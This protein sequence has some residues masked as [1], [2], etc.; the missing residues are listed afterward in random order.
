MVADNYD[1]ERSA[2]VGNFDMESFVH[3]VAGKCTAV[4]PH[5][6]PGN[7]AALDKGVEIDSLLAFGSGAQLRTG[8]RVDF[9]VRPSF[10]YLV[11]QAQ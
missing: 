7:Q 2:A 10:E 3:R 5:I 9:E 4:E 6:E 1:K 8:N 11:G